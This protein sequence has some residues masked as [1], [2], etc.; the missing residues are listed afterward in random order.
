MQITVVVLFFIIIAS[1]S[2]NLI[3]NFIPAQYSL[4]NF[5]PNKLNIKNVSYIIGF[6]GFIVGILWPTLLSQLSILSLIDTFSCFFGP[7]SGVIIINYYIIN[8][9]NINI[10]DIHSVSAESMFYF[11][12][13]WHLKAMYSIVIGFIF[14]SSAI[15][16][17]SLTFLQSYAWIIGALASGITYYLLDRR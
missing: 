11:S 3:A 14:A 6:L 15:W 13:G 1:A 12:K 7:I 16:N 8:K 17:Y 2:T 4:I 9:S 10:K 5:Q